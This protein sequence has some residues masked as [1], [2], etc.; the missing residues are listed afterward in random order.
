[1][2]CA[3]SSG[4]GYGTCTAGLLRS[5]CVDQ[6]DCTEGTCAY[7]TGLGRGE[8]TDGELGS[9]CVSPQHCGMMHC[10]TGGNSAGICQAGTANQPCTRAQDCASGMCTSS[11]C[12]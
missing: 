5:A 12:Q 8:C 1:M 10:Y 6:A 7:S 3:Y 11:M 4:N 9:F 2:L